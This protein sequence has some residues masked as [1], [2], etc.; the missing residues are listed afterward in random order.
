MDVDEVGGCRYLRE[1]SHAQHSAEP[2]VILD[3]R[4]QGLLQQTGPQLQV[5][6]GREDLTVDGVQGLLPV[7]VE[8]RDDPG[9]FLLLRPQAIEVPG[10]QFPLGLFTPLD[11]LPE[12]T[13]R[14]NSQTI[15]NACM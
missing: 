1:R 11:E 13:L 12:L 7:S 8:L 6:E 14:G 5:R 2:V 4:G 15:S 9:H 3:Q 10:L